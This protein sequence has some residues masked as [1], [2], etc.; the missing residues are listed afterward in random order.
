MNNLQIYLTVHTILH[1]IVAMCLTTVILP[2][3]DEQ[4]ISAVP[5]H[6]TVDPH[7]LKLSAISNSKL[8]SPEYTS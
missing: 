5:L 8:F 1:N 6:N 2:V 3:S 4:Y 7:Y